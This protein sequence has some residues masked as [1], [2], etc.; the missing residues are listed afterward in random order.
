MADVEFYI[1][2]YLTE[3][4]T[5]LERAMQEAV[6]ILETEAK[7]NA[8]VDTGR[9]RGSIT[10]I[11]RYVADDVI[12][13]RIGTNVEYAKYVELGTSKQ[14]AQ[15]FLRSALRNKYSEVVSII[16]EAIE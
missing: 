4:N 16:Q 7:K 2:D 11:V 6:L 5:E 13:G 10:N 15:P 14:A 1:D 12:E 9:L 8:P 3:L